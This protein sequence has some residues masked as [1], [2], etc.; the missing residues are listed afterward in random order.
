MSHIDPVYAIILPDQIERQSFEL[1]ESDVSSTLA[2]SI[3]TYAR[4]YRIAGSMVD[5][6]K[7]LNDEKTKRLI[8]CIS[9]NKNISRGHWFGS[10]NIHK[11]IDRELVFGGN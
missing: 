4:R 5:Y 1:T 9:S 8:R 3:D 7:T 2:R 6:K 11:L 10:S